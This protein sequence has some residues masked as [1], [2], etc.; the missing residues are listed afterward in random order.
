MKPYTPLKTAVIIGVMIFSAAMLIIAL[1]CLWSIFDDL[2]IG[3]VVG[4]GLKLLT[5]LISAIVGII[6]TFTTVRLLR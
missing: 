1:I 3:N 5:G 6:L 2:L 4:A